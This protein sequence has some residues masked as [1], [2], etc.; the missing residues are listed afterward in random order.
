MNR[1]I[2]AIAFALGAG[3]ILWIGVG[4]VGTDV[5]ALLV[6]LVIG[7][8]YLL[9]FVELLQF[10]RATATLVTALDN[11]PAPLDS[12]DGWLRQL[13]PSLQEAVRLRIEE[14]GRASCRERV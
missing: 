4:F 10:R 1:L 14:I 2:L 13:H 12:L 7:A 6:T 3:A 8:V 5:L 11:V 9:G